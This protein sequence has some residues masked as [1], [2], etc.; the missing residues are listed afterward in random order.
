MNFRYLCGQDVVWLLMEGQQHLSVPSWSF[1]QQWKKWQ[2]ELLVYVLTLN[3]FNLMV[4]ILSSS[5]C[6]DQ[7]LM[8]TIRILNCYFRCLHCLLLQLHM[9]IF[10]SRILTKSSQVACTLVSQRRVGVFAFHGCTAPI[11]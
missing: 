7:L 5:R 1:L 6:I 10:T 4:S 8:K 3:T 11:T 9:E 2:M